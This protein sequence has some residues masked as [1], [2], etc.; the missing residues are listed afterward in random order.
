MR[1]AP[2]RPQEGISVVDALGNQ[3]RLARPAQ[4]VVS[5]A[6]NLTEIVCFV[7]GEKQL[8]GVTDFCRYPPE[9]R[10]KPKVGGIINP[11]LEKVLSLK[12]DLLLV[13][14]G[15]DL[16]IIER[17]RKSGV[18]VYAADPKS[19]RDVIELV[20]TVGHLLG[21][22]AE[23]GAAARKLE[24]RL[25]ALTSRAVPASHRPK[26]LAVVELEPLFVAGS[27][28]YLDDLLR[29]AGLENAAGGEE[30]WARWSSER[31]LNADPDLILVVRM[32]GPTGGAAPD[33]RKQ[34]IHRSPW[35]TLRAVKAGAVY[36]VTDDLVTI[37]GPRLLDGLEEV[38]SIRHDYE[39]R[40]AARG[41]A[42][43]G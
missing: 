35:R 5:L 37:P 17:M 28:S 9:V 12:P 38:V 39:R 40:L 24:K 19:L 11:S 14:R 21:R 26:A 42:G 2:E 22:D 15:T 25:A 7:G 36:T 10:S 23:A 41:V 6:P 3:V 34:L 16:R 8:V 18:P 27:G 29:L 43:S 1:D 31:V 30:P 33:L 32:Q 4:R 20:R 13:A